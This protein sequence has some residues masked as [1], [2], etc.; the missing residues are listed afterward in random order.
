MEW[1][2]AFQGPLTCRTYMI[3]TFYIDAIGVNGRQ[4]AKLFSIFYGIHPQIHIVDQTNQCDSK[5]NKYRF[6]HLEWYVV[7]EQKYSYDCF[8]P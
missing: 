1:I 4:L 6:T 7:H 3:H 5:S 2:Q 8:C